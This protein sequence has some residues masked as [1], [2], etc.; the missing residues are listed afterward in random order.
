MP[1]ITELGK[2]RQEDRELKVI[3]GYIASLIPE[4]L[5]QKDQEK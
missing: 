4:N 2:W 5:S 3:T 1:V